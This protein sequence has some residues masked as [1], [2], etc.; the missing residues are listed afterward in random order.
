VPVLPHDN[1]GLL[2]EKLSV[3]G[4][5]LLLEALGGWTRGEIIPRP[6]DEAAASYFPQ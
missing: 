6:Q 2:T 3:V 4:A 5:H 1:T